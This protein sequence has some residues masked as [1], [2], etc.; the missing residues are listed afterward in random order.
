MKWIYSFSR[1]I[2]GGAHGPSRARGFIAL[3]TASGA[4]VTC[5][6]RGVALSIISRSPFAEA[7][8]IAIRDEWTTRH[9]A[10]RDCAS[11]YTPGSDLS[12]TSISLTS[13]DTM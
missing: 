9:D 2:S 5:E 3:Q 7:G 11:L 1:P 6:R 12:S 8:V 10:K 13:L 4:E